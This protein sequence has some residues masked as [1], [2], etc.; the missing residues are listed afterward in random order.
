MKNVLGLSSI[1]QLISRALPL[2]TAQVIAEMMEKKPEIFLAGCQV[3]PRS[4]ERIFGGYIPLFGEKN[5]SWFEIAIAWYFTQNV[6]LFDT[7]FSAEL[8]KTTF[9]SNFPALELL[10][11]VGNPIYIPLDKEKNGIFGYIVCVIGERWENEKTKGTTGLLSFI[12]S[13]SPKEVPFS[14]FV[15]ESRGFGFSFPD[16]YEGKQNEVDTVVQSFKN[17]VYYDDQIAKE[18]INKLIFLLS[19]EPEATS[20][21]KSHLSNRPTIKKHKRRANTIYAPSQPK[22]H[23]F[24]IEFGNEIRKASVE[25]GT[26]RTV[27]PHIRSAHWHTFLAGPDRSKRVIRW[28]KPI[29]VHSRQASEQSGAFFLG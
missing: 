21:R 8:R 22:V 26:D 25:M 5:Q 27:R 17:E 4:L 9:S 15:L 28:L 18:I 23:M 12:P 24:G 20:W 7:E 6:A 13:L 11:L 2:D 10:R 19:D 1:T 3:V 14:G 29:F 16:E